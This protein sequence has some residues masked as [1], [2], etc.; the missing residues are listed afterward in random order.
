MF[1]FISDNRWVLGTDETGLM[2]K[3]VLSFTDDSPQLLFDGGV[4]CFSALKILQMFYNILFYF[5]NS[6]V[7]F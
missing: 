6:C 2:I 3:S 5:K 1:V 7:F 4:S